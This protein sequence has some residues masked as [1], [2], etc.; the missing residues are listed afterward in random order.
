MDGYSQCM[1]TIKGTIFPLPKTF[2][3]TENKESIRHQAH[4]FLQGLFIINWRFFVFVTVVTLDKALDCKRLLFIKINL[5][6]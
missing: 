6:F 3:P 5:T 4:H 1:L 2:H